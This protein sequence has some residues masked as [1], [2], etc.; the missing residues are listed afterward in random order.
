M[1]NQDNP[2]NDTHSEAEANEVTD[3]D[4]QPEPE[5][6]KHSTTQQGGRGLAVFGVLLALLALVTAGWVYYQVKFQTNENQARNQLDALASQQDL[7]QLQS[8]VT[9]LEEELPQLVQSVNQNK[10]NIQQLQQRLED[11]PDTTFDAEPLEQKINTLQQ[12]LTAVKKQEREHS[13]EPQT[14]DYLS[15]LARAQSINALETVQLLLNQ[16]HIPQAIDILKQWR[17]NEHLPLA[18]QTRLQQ[19]VTILSNAESPH[20]N[21]L[22]QELT[23]LKE[24]ITALSLTT[25]NPETEQ[26]AWYERFITIKKIQA[27]NQNINSADLQQLKANVSHLIAQAELALTLKQPDL[28]RNALHQ[29][30]QT[31]TNTALDTEALVQQIQQLQAQPIVTQVPGGLGIDALIQQ[32]EGIT[33]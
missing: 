15:A 1:D 30:E 26:P 7:K 12:Q 8:R 21:Q 32:L 18:V 14:E 20:I 4:Q 6:I 31:L 16:Q 10:Q 28:W 17:N 33:E 5:D 22:R 2:Q 19:L 13:F 25:E 11:L 29:A 23:V 9:Q 27:E 24:H 3:H